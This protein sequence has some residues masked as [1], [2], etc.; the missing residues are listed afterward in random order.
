MPTTDIFERLS[1]GE[2]ILANDPDG[3]KMREASFVTKA[4]LL[5]MNNTS[6]PDEIRNSLSKITKTQTTVQKRHK[7]E[8][9][10]GFGYV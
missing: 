6:N 10:R 9:E 4:L 8:K 3:Y 7:L 2:T 5:K 1:Q